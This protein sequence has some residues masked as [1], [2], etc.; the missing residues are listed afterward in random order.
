MTHIRVGTRPENERNGAVSGF[1]RSSPPEGASTVDKPARSSL[2]LWISRQPVRDRPQTRIS[3]LRRKGRGVRRDDTPLAAQGA[4]QSAGQLVPAPA[5]V[6]TPA[7]RCGA[8]GLDRVSR[9]PPR[10]GVTPTRRLVRPTDGRGSATRGPRALASRP[11]RRPSRAAGC[12]SGSD[13]RPAPARRAHRGRSRQ[14]GRPRNG[15]RGPS[16]HHRGGGRPDHTRRGHRRVG[17]RNGGEA[18]AGRP[19]RPGRPGLLRCRVRQRRWRVGSPS[20]GWSCR[21]PV[22]R[23]G[24]GSWSP[25]LRWSRASRTGSTPPEWEP[26]CLVALT[27]LTPAADRAWQALRCAAADKRVTEIGMGP[28]LLQLLDRMQIVVSRRRLARLRTT[29]TEPRKLALP[30]LPIGGLPW[31]GYRSREAT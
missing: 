7:T 10:I 21:R 19:P 30:N 8:R 6:R 1:P 29:S 27:Y 5:A 4:P 16:S 26:R 9:P 13:P 2:R 20:P 31:T 28:V 22:C 12:A 24:C 3:I 11:G 15:R 14:S 18:G 17:P 23:G 25:A